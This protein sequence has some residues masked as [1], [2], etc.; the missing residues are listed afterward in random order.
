MGTCTAPAAAARELALR[1]GPS[2]T[3][4]CTAR[5]PAGAWT[6]VTRASVG[7]DTL[8]ADGASL[9]ARFAA[10]GR[11][12]WPVRYGLRQR[13]LIDLLRA[14]AR[15]GA[16]TR[17]DAAGL[18]VRGRAVRADRED[19]RGGLGDVPRSGWL[20]FIRAP[21]VQRSCVF[22]RGLGAE[23]RLHPHDRDLG[24]LRTALSERVPR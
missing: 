15:R 22:L 20:L 6:R 10:I 24:V 14:G 18:R 2:S 17:T 12:S 4:S 5:G 7:T 16:C 1:A 8:P 21:R 9:R 11:G 19:I 3:A 23:P 13:R